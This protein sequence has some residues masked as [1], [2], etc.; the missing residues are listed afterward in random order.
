VKALGDVV[1]VP[2]AQSVPVVET[3]PDCLGSARW[4]CSLPNGEEFDVECPRCYHGGFSPSDGRIQERYEV[5]GR[6]TKGT[7]TRIEVREGVVEYGTT[8]GYIYSDEDLCEDEATAIARS[9]VKTRA[10]HDAEFKRMDE[11]RRRKGRPRKNRETGAREANDMDFG[12]GSANY[13]RG[14]IRRSF[15]E[16]IRWRDYAERKGTAIDLA[17]MLANAMEGKP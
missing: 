11:Y 2:T 10:W 6:A 15:K 5:V 16:A 12:G 14:E 9:V 3:C 13:A 17:A 8:S 4:H 1:W 7:I